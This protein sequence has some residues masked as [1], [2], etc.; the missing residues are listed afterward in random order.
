MPKS[1]MCYP[2]GGVIKTLYAFVFSPCTYSSLPILLELMTL[3]VKSAYYI[4]TILIQY[5]LNQN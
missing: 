1:P 4:S 3:V 5:I 2:S